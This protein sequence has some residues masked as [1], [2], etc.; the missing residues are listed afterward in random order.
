M[1]PR[2]PL[3][4]TPTFPPILDLP[5]HNTSRPEICK[6]QELYCCIYLGVPTDWIH[7][8]L[9]KIPPTA[10]SHQ[11]LLQVLNSAR[12]DSPVKWFNRFHR[13]DLTRILEG[14]FDSL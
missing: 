11:N 8:S 9:T 5:Q 12:Y 7:L 2:S 13:S 10:F 3:S 1:G 4:W 6:N 14:P